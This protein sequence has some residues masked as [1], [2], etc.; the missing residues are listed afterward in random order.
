MLAPLHTG[1]AK[2]TL[3]DGSSR[4]AAVSGGFI[5]VSKGETK[6]VATT[7]EF[8]DEIDVERANRA[9]QKAEEALKNAKDDKSIEL[10]KAKLL[11]AISR[12][13]VAT[14]KV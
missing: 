7:F 14:G 4:T 1:R 8:S 3:K 11:R 9:K 6:V 12:I 5:L 2:L 10:A 13:N